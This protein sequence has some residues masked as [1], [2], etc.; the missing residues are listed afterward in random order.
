[1]GCFDSEAV[2]GDGIDG[3]A[4]ATRALGAPSFPI[5][6]PPNPTSTTPSLQI[7][8][9]GGCGWGLRTLEDVKKG[10]LVFEYVGEVIDDDLLEVRGGADCLAVFAFDVPA[11]D[12]IGKP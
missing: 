12:G 2:G 8:K 1:M 3:R 11:R 7:F 5:Q 6:H 10:Q 4:V 9:E